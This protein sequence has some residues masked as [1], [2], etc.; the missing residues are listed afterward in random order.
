VLRWALG[1]I[2]LAAGVLHILI[3]AP[4]V[5][6]APL[7][8]ALAPSV[9]LITGLCEIAGATALMFGGVRLRWWA[10]VMLALYAMCVWPA[11]VHHAMLD[12][13]SGGGLGWWYH[14]PRLAFQPVV[15]WWALFAGRVVDRPF[16][17]SRS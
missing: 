1:L 17:P 12:I 9:V 4:F 2:Y 15:I 16:G 14:A 11:N 7:P 6:I 5:E 8:A 3:P 13:S 10:G